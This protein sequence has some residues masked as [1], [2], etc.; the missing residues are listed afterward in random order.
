MK[1]FAQY[2][3]ETRQTFDY[4]IK[5]LGDADAELI[6][7]L[8]EK[9]QQFDVVKMTEPKKT[10]IQKTLS[11]FPGAENDSMTFMDVTFN[12]PATPPQITQ[13]AELCG[14]NPNH[15][16]IE[17]KDYAESID[18]EREGYEAQPD[19]VLGSDESDPSAASKEASENF[20]ADP[21]DRNIVGN[22]YKSDFTIAGGKTPP[23][24]FTTDTPSSTESPIM[25]TN[26]IP[27]VKAS[28]GSSA[29]ENRKDGPPGKNKK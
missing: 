28:N 7:K 22:E 1:S 10:P 9:L 13:I 29:P 23:A 26:K 20:A 24:K 14:M 18:E 15:I 27:V 12:Y 3:V 19:P 5:I 4:R 11:D 25:G 8:E 6:N 16:C 21:Y 17:A 2:L